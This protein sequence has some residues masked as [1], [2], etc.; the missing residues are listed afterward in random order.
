MEDD[1]LFKSQRLGFR[2]WQETDIAFL[3]AI[4]ADPETMEFFPAVQT[5]EHTQA[6]VELMRHNQAQKGYCY[7]AVDKLANSAFIGFIGLFDKV[8]PASFTPCVDVGWRL[9][10]AEWGNGYATEGAK[11]CLEYAF[12][13][14]GLHKVYAIAPVVN[15]KSE[16]VMVKAGMKKLLEFQHPQLANDERLRQCLLYIA[17]K[18]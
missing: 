1:Y 13:E 16:A 8:F 2:L 15:K 10:R 11:R 3:A 7:Y 12:Q 17:E 4:N 14:L 18:S 6:F 9:Q 5:Y